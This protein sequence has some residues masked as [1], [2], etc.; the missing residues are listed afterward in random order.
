MRFPI[1][2]HARTLVRGGAV[3]ASLSFLSL[4]SCGREITGPGGARLAHAIAFVAQFPGPL[5]GVAEGAGSVVPFDRVRIILRRADQSI[6]LDRTEPFSAG[7]DTLAL[8]LRVTLSATASAE[9]EPLFLFLRFLNAAGDTVFAG[10]PV[11][12]TAVPAGGTRPPP[13][14]VDVVVIHVGPGSSA[15][16]ATIAPE[17]L[18]VMADAPFVFTATGR[19]AAQAL[20]N[21]A[22]FVFTSR[23]TTRARLNAVGAGAGIAGPQ[24]GTAIIEV[25][26]AGGSPPDTGYLVVTPRPASLTATAGAS[27]SAPAGALL[28]ESVRVRLLA[29]D[30]LPIAGHALTAAVTTGG[31]GISSTT[32]TTDA[33][34][35]IAFA[36][37]LG[38]LAGTQTVTVS[39]GTGV[40]N[41]VVS[42]T[43]SAAPTVATQLVVTQQPNAVLVVGQNLTQALLIEAR[44]ASG[45]R[46]PAFTD[47]V[48]IAFGTNPSG[49]TLGGTVR[50]AAVGGIAT[51]NAWSVGA[52]GSGYT[53]VAAASG[54]T[55]ATTNPF[56]VG[57]GGA[58]ALTIVSGDAQTGFVSQ[59]LSTPVVVRVTDALLNPLAGVS[60]NF[61][62][63]S[64]GGSLGVS[65]VVTGAAGLATLSSWTLGA[66]PGAN[67][68]SATVAGV[69][70]L[71]ISATG[72]LPP[73]AI[74]L[75]VFGSNV[76]GVARAG[77]LNVRLLQPAPIGGLTVS[78]VSNNTGILTIAS[79]GTIAFA[80]G[81]TL[82]TIEVSGIALGN[83]VVVGSAAG[84]A[85][86]T[87]TV[88]VSL[89][90]I[91]L[92]PTLNV[93]LAQTRSLPVQLSA[94]APAGGVAVALTS[95]NPLAGLTT[96][97]TVVVAAGTQSVNAIVDGLALGT[98]TI[99][100]TNPNY[101]LDRT[102]VSVTAELNIVATTVALNGTFG[103]PITVRL[104]SGGSPV[105]A[106][107][108]G[109][110][111]TLSSDNA[112]CATL[113]PSAS[114]DAGF[115]SVAI[116]VTYG[117]SVALPC[118]TRLRVTGPAGFAV[119]SVTASVAVVPVISRAASSVGSGLQRNIGASLG[120]SNHG[121]VTVT[122][123]SLDN[124]RV[125][126]AP[127]VATAGAGSYQTTI[128]PGASTI[129]LVIS[130]VAG[131]IADTVSVRI[132][133]PGFVTATFPVYVWQP[134]FQLSSL[135][136][137]G[138][139][140][141]ADDAFW[142]NIGT[143]SA[144]AG[145]AISV[146][147]EVR[148][149]GGALTASIIN[150]TP[151]IGTLV[152]TAGTA[153][154]ITVTI[155]E[156]ISNSPTSVAAGGVAFRP[157]AA[158]V[159]SIRSTVTGLRALA[160][161][162]GTV[163]LSQ[164]TISLAT[165]YLGAGLQRARTVS[166]P[167]SPAP[168]GGT[169]ITLA[170]SR[171]GVVRFAPNATTAG[172]DTLDVVIPAGGT[173]T[174]F[175]VQGADDIVADTV[176]VS[177]T[178]PGFA[179]AVADQ[180][181]WRAVYQLTGLN[182][183]G[184]PLSVDDPFY[185]SIGTP[186]SPT[187]T[188][189]SVSDVRRATAPP[190]SVTI[191]SGTPATGSLMPLGG[192]PVA[193]VVVLIAPGVA[194]SPT[195]VAAG[196]V[197]M[198][199]LAGGTTL[200]TASIPGV[201]VRAVA[202]ASS[203]VTVST[204][205][206]S[207]PTDY[208]GSGLQRARGVTLGAPAPAG[209]VPVTI[210]ADRLG[211]ARF[212]PNAIS[213]G[214]DTLVVTV[215]QG[216]SSA[217]F[218]VQGVEGIV[219]DTVTLTASSPG[220]AS[221]IA[222]Q[223]VWQG[224]VDF[225]GL[226]ATL[227]TLAPD[228]PFQVIVG[229]ASSPL[230]TVIAVADN[231]RFGAVPL[232]ATVVSNTSTV[233]QLTTTA[234]T[235]D[236]ITVQIPAGVR[237]SPA[238][239]AGGGVAFQT[240]TTGTTVVSAAIPNFRRT[241]AAAG[242]TVTVTAPALTLTAPVSIGSGLQVGA[243]GSVNAAQH[244]GIS[245][246]VRS[247]N[248]AL[249]R[250]AP[251]ATITASDSI[252]IPLANGA[253]S[254]SYV[255]A[256]EDVVT[257][258]T[259]ITARAVGFTD[260]ATTATVVTPMIALTGVVATRPAGGADDPFQVQI[261]VPVTNLTALSVTQARRAGAAPLVVTVTSTAPA[262]ASLVMTGQ[263]AGTLT[264][265]IPPTASVSPATVAAGGVALRYVAPGAATLSIS[266]PVVAST[267]A[268]STVAVSVTVPILTLGALPAVGAGLQVSATGSL[269]APQHGGINVVVRS[270]NPAIARV[271]ANATDI[272]TDSIII[273]LADGV[274]AFSYVLAGVENVTGT[275][276]ITASSPGFTSASLNSTVVAPMLDI[277]GLVAS[278]AALGADDPFIVRV[279]IPAAGGATL[280]AT[281]N[282]RAGAAPLVISVS[283]LTP[284]VGTLVTTAL[285][286]ATVSVQ[287]P[288]GTSGSAS[289]VAAGG[290]AFRYLTAGTSVVQPTH[291]SIARTSTTGSV[292][293]TVTP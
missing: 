98:T 8:D 23:D 118:N 30:G 84:Y 94:P 164:P 220:Y 273:P 45:V 110:P 2:R 221:G 143:P 251:S 58:A 55:S 49:A 189:I 129:P 275:P 61:A 234:R 124:S 281:Q 128:L 244:G 88:P 97:D 68:L 136:P 52:I 238:T 24:R 197:A 9:G 130:G 280:S 117:G 125:L 133:A 152:R 83:A 65:S 19:D 267:T 5:A 285:T 269:N 211:V 107:A 228:D 233:G 41:L 25:R 112:A 258:Q 38:G 168:A 96:T 240:L 272:A 202:G 144:P 72:V 195:S 22:Y 16:S 174:T 229:T 53:V 18:T 80:A 78:V 13:A 288:A 35:Q 135:N 165:D 139:T 89:N 87:L 186:S 93:P 66:T 64:G 29:T 46:V 277:N 162:V 200:V 207:L 3:L 194:N 192:G 291:P 236:T 104:E 20:V 283:S 163:T 201:G 145:T 7:I 43:A 109:V 219:A 286:A 284:A 54:L 225:S 79:L 260:A 183:T 156:R 235:G 241:A 36:W 116:N 21:G 27:Q 249:V 103:A 127:N 90:L 17:S 33:N 1:R 159:A 115:V 253:T 14:A 4:L 113:P 173:S 95:S 246:I 261:G 232:T 231:V 172:V 196:G 293:V 91:S 237:V 147:D 227:N 111:L 101:A 199:Y 123:T 180:R 105:A 226:P 287:I 198:R 206:I 170:A 264:V 37:T 160:G 11:P 39:A 92:P 62:V 245:V 279:G 70:P 132:E 34:G 142:V 188:S 171:L 223:R 28:S 120:A 32:F 193:S 271:A 81:Q 77:T 12:V 60:V 100:A 140:L 255:I 262:I 250:V 276:A 178:A 274:T 26:V 59:L 289:T 47:S 187:G 184:T 212:A 157:L 137:T 69:P 161:S 67:A 224:I 51:F 179:S 15:V 99:T 76:V 205:A 278:R 252:I 48:T 176:Q 134:V 268:S 248:P 259:S 210:T 239:V 243:S 266:H 213:V 106:P 265:A 216:A 6:A 119:D 222:E 270:A 204:T 122:V 131:L 182:T 185:V 114:I 31:G 154:S 73:P 181:V 292:T 148:V 290:A 146:F 151:G 256:A 257:G 57:S 190:L 85:P 75:T 158:G 121:G 191:T 167:G 40:T 71:T 177:A 208:V 254:F 150:D 102:V 44:D 282:V 230:G 169:R 218:F 215:A 126:V 217:S 74:D 138:S 155:A 141:A 166:T 108:G 242:L 56:D 209:G 42:A 263:V 203:T 214:V 149:G 50:V 82:R 63:T 10:G 86:D 247:S 175:F 153:D